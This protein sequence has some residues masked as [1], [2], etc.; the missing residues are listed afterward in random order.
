MRKSQETVEQERLLAKLPFARDASFDSYYRQHEALCVENTRVDLLKQHQQWG[1]SHPKPLYWLSGMAGTGKS[2]IAR[3]LAHHF[4]S[5]G[6]LGG[7]FFFSKSSGEA[8]TAVNFVGTLARHLANTSPGL[9]RSICE[10]ISSHE[11][12]IRQGLRNQWTELVMAPLSTP[13]P[14]GRSKLNIVIDALDECGSDDEIRVILQLCVEVKNLKE[15]NVGVFVTSRPEIAIRLGFEAMPDII[16]QKLD[17][18]DVP[19][20]IVEHDL[21]VLLERQLDQIAA[22]HKL[23]GWP[24]QEDILSLVRQC[25]CLFI[26]ATTACRYIAEPDWDPEER[27]A[28]VLSAG[29][30]RS[31]NTAALDTMYLHALTS[32]LI[33]GRTAA[34]ATKVCDRFRQVVGSIVALFDELSIIGLAGLLDLPSKSVE[35]SLT[36][37]HSVLNIPQ[38][39]E[40]PI[41]LLHPSFR[42]FLLDQSRCTND[43][44]CVDAG[45]MH[46]ELAKHCFRV[47]S[48][49]LKRNMGH[50]TTPGSSPPDVDRDRLDTNLPPYVRYACQY[51]VEH[52]GSIGAD[53]EAGQSYAPDAEI[54]SFFQKNLLNWLEAMSLMAKMSHA[55]LMITRLKDLVQ[56]CQAVPDVLFFPER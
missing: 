32:S 22:Q 47:M 25:D 16:H 14:T 6:T 52:L 9:R 23:P 40:S 19:R 4:D 18:R 13:S 30:A 45:L 43:S 31:G 38:D 28:E 51:W 37:L 48:T 46:Q 7:S 56:V 29:S 49:C 35:I 21:S 17:L 33:S 24:K 3:T 41:R 20:P 27:L 1:A 42:D 15:I 54:H 26:Y 44:I 50:L 8:N 55:V 36:K 53:R 11:D 10:A 34:E 12:V 2:T 5:V 39:V